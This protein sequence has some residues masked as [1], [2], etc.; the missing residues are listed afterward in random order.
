MLRAAIG[1]F[2]LGLIALLLGVNGIAGVSLEVGRLLLI[3]FVVL[4][5]VSFVA[6]IITGRGPKNLP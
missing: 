6:S 5:L 2:V 4:A 1:F 3:A